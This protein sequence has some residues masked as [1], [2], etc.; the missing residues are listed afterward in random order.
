MDT[1]YV[2]GKRYRLEFTGRLRKKWNETMA[3]LE[4]ALG[5]IQIKKVQP[6]VRP[7]SG[8]T[9]RIMHAGDTTRIMAR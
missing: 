2:K 7:A 1:I 9:T 3:N 8:E 4:T 5:T 6:R